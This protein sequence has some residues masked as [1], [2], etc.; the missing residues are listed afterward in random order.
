MESFLFTQQD[1]HWITLGWGILQWIIGPDVRGFNSP[2][3]VQTH[4]KPEDLWLDR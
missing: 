4:F 1:N 3:T 2:E